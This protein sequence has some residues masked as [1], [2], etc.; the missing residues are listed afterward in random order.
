MRNVM[1]P[2]DFEKWCVLEFGINKIN[3]NSQK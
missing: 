3:N 1:N 2:E